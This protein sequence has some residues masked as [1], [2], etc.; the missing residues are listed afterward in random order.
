MKTHNANPAPKI[1]THS[2][3]AVNRLS[4]AELVAMV[5]Q[6][7]A[8]ISTLQCDNLYLKQE[9][10]KLKRMIFGSKSERYV[11]IETGQ[12]TLPL[13]IPAL[14]ASQTHDTIAKTIS[15]TLGPKEQP[16]EGLPKGHARLPINGNIP[17]IDEIIEPEGDLSNA[18]KIGELIT[19][20]LDYT[21]GKLYVR[22][23]IRPKYVLA[24]EEGIVSAELPTLPIPKSNA[25]PGLLAHIFISKF[26]DHIPYYRQIQQFQRQGVVIAD[27]TI[28][29]WF[30]ASCQLLQ[31]LYDRL[32]GQVQK[33][34]YI[35]ADETPIAVL[36]SDKP[37][38]THQGYHWV[39]KAHSEKLVCFQ[40]RKG[41]GREGP[42]E[43]LKDFQGALQSDGYNAYDMFE[44]KAGIT[45]LACMAHARRKFD[46]A[47]TDDAHRAEYALQQIQLLYH[48]E[49]KARNLDLTPEERMQ[50][51]N[52]ESLPVLESIQTWLK[53]QVADVLPKSAIGKAVNYTLN[54]WPRL[55]RYTQSGQYEIDNNLVEN[56]IRPIALGRKNYLF[57]GSHQ[58]AQ[59][60]AMMYSFLGSCK[61]N[62][63]EPLAWFTDILTRIPD[64]KMS[65]L[66]NLLPNKWKDNN[67]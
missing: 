8:F 61:L 47:R 50:M 65:Q 28:S 6:Q 43:F 1:A 39:Y 53:A 37:G 22:R 44:N 15:Y 34:N 2:E 46:Q 58:A 54:L 12:L 23:I 60:A 13:N 14:E 19:E 55:V 26:V 31:P 62:N 42:K 67:K 20:V 4:H 27:A 25:G 29:G 5:N 35:M 7:G 11:P 45:L 21:P 59:G 66:D 3:E 17:R 10:D 63:V 48:I 40:Y 32:M 49:E 16:Q 36:E 38:A 57:A 9:L 52:T 56:S 33:S 18:K 41:R 51:R 64:C 30:M 24:S